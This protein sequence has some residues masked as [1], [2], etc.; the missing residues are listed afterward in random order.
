MQNPHDRR[1]RVPELSPSLHK[2]V[3]DALSSRPEDASRNKASRLGIDASL[4][5][6]WQAFRFCEGSVQGSED[7]Q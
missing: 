7:A 6:S 5:I 2:H 3:I 4:Q 1:H